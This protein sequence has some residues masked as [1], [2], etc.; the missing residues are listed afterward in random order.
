MEAI[1][2]KQQIN[3]IEEGI[4]KWQALLLCCVDNRTGQVDREKEE[5]YWSQIREAQQHVDEVE[6]NTETTKIEHN[7]VLI[8]FDT[9]GEGW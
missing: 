8:L 3:R 7:L 5:Y 4:K 1:Q 9:H 2:I 6:A